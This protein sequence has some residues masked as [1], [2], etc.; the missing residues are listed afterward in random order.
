MTRSERNG[1][2]ERVF[3]GGARGCEVQNGEK[4]GTAE[5]WEGVAKGLP[6]DGESCG[7]SFSQGHREWSAMWCVVGRG[8]TETR[9]TAEVYSSLL[10]AKA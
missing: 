3:G 2:R 7:P 4:D 9:R 1:E 6:R 10:N 8:R 5:V